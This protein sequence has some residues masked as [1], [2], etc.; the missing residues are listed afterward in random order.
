MPISFHQV[1]DGD[2]L[3]TTTVREAIR[4]S[5][6]HWISLRLL[7]GIGEEHE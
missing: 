6:P 5:E 1:A 2:R 7:L 4:F 3:T